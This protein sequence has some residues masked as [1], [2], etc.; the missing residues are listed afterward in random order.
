LM[1]TLVSS[2]KKHLLKDMQH[3]VH[4]YIFN[5]LCYLQKL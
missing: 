5:A 1:I 4:I 3:S 2:P